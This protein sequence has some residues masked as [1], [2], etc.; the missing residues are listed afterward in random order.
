[1]I[2]THSPGSSLE[3]SVSDEDLGLVDE[4]GLG[5][6]ANIEAPDLTA[7]VGMRDGCSF[8]ASSV[9]SLGKSSTLE[10]GADW[11]TELEPLKSPS[12]VFCLP[13]NCK[14]K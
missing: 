12:S 6:F 5:L 1:M 14:V 2:L 10:A 13:V 3:P 4:P 11:S 7:L 9:G 8:G